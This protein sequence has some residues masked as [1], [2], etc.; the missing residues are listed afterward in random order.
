MVSELVGCGGRESVGTQY[1]KKPC[2]AIVSV[3][4]LAWLC[5]VGGG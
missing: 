2:K 1:E 3:G 4:G 5:C